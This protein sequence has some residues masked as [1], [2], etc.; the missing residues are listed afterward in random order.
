MKPCNLEEFLKMGKC[1]REVDQGLFSERADL[2]M[3]NA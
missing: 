1:Y 3:T 2:T